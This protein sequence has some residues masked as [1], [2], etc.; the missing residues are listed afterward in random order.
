MDEACLPSLNTSL[1]SRTFGGLF[2]VDRADVPSLLF[3]ET[4]LGVVEKF[5]F[6]TSCCSGVHHDLIFA[7]T[8]L[9]S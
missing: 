4:D 5:S 8:R 3:E 9:P 7:P 2:L 6:M 1:D